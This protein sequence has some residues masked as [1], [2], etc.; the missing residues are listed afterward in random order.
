[1]KTQEKTE[2]MERMNE[3][4]FDAA[5]YLKSMPPCDHLHGHTYSLK[6]L[7]LSGILKGNVIVNF[8]DI[9]FIIKEYDHSLLIPKDDSRFW[10]AFAEDGKLPVKLTKVVPIDG[11]PTVERVGL[12]IAQRILAQH[13]NITKV[14]FSI[15]EGANQGVQVKV[16]R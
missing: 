11:E 6:D 8:N 10:R 1:M 3:L 7:D 15:F 4:H 16:S 9:K 13:A 5:H 14:S 2:F 12:A